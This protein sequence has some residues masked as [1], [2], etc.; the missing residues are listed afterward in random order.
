MKTGL[1]INT[2]SMAHDYPGHPEHAGRMA[3][4]REALEKTDLLKTAAGIA[5]RPAIQEELLLA[6]DREMIDRVR[7]ACQNAAHLDADTYTTTSSWQAALTAVGG[8]IDLTAAVC[9]G[10]IDNGFAVVRPPGH[11][12]TR[13]Q[14]MGFCLFSNVAIAAKTALQRPEVRRVAIVDFDIHHG[15]GTQD[16]VADDPD[17]LFVSTHS[18]PF[19]PGTGSIRENKPD[20]L[21]NCPLPT[22]SG[23]AEFEEVYDRLIIPA[24]KRFGPD[25]ILV[26]AGFDGHWQDPLG[27]FSLTL[28]GYSMMVEKLI[29]LAE[30]MCGGKILFTL[31]GG[32]NLHVLGKA[33][34]NCISQL[35]GDKPRF[36]SEGRPESSP[37]PGQKLELLVDEIAAIHNL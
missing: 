35:M 16:I 9:T 15:N 33:V 4:I 31:E 8:L 17:I 26:S 24:L 5:P 3:A 34:V 1:T 36:V 28:N 37:N 2:E 12:A 6:H 22:G 19:Y 27:N 20:S 32:Y 29:A 14:S 18:Y 30:E 11:H 13:S 23:D 25:L 7:A 10:A 21:L